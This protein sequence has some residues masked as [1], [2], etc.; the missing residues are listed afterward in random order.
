M[1]L[2]RSAQTAMQFLLE[3]A[4]ASRRVRK[5][6]VGRQ[7]SRGGLGVRADYSTA[8]TKRWCQAGWR[9][10]EQLPGITTRIPKQARSDSQAR[11][12]TTRR[13]FPRAMTAPPYS[14]ALP[15]PFPP[16]PYTHTQ[17]F[18]FFLLPPLQAT[19][20]KTTPAFF[21]D[22]NKPADSKCI[23]SG[24]GR[25]V[26]AGERVGEGRAEGRL[27]RID[28]RLGVCD[29]SGAAGAAAGAAVATVPRQKFLTSFLHYPHPPPSHSHPQR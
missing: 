22:F 10:S 24:G 9:Q 7:R 6:R 14:L 13:A 5:H 19:M 15:R 17:A 16:L 26:C 29:M 8:K 2:L 11:H 1:S 3:W 18:R 4:A 23:V 12:H 27:E 28:M 25:C 21:K 20:S